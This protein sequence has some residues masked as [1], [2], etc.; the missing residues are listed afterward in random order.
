VVINKILTVEKGNWKM[1]NSEGVFHTAT[2]FGQ[3]LALLG[4][5]GRGKSTFIQCMADQAGVSYVE[6][7]KLCGPSESELKRR[8]QER[9]ERKLFCQHR[10]K[11]VQQALRK[12]LQVAKS[13]Y[14]ALTGEDSHEWYVI[15]DS[16]LE[17]LDV[18][19]LTK[20]QAKTIFDLLPEEIIHKGFTW[21][22]SD[23]VVRDDIYLFIRDN[24]ELIAPKIIVN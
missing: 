22:F 18:E 4:T 2:S 12:S 9:L 3:N 21:D 24:K 6:M 19:N 8:E 13:V 10:S 16:A 11:K 17:F 7:E 15:H 20:E 1:T 14:W 23:T 5:T